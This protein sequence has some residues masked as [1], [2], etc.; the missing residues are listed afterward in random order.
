MRVV[1]GSARGRRLI[2]PKGDA[3]R[4]TSDFVREA[5]FN[6][7]QSIVEWEGLDAADLFAGTG[8]L[9]IEALSR[10]AASCLFVDSDRRAADAVR[11]NLASTG[12]A[13]RGSVIVR[14]VA[15]WVASA[16]ALHVVFADPPYAFDDWGA[17][18]SVRAQLV[19]AES[20]RE[21]ALGPRWMILKSKRYGSTVVTLFE[22]QE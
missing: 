13:D 7:L 11:T 19:V 9:G 5:I 14:D 21:V 12:L 22:P 4:P 1:G 8:A 10:G 20:D 15:S 3:T 17:I 2:A 6:T 18:G 16:P